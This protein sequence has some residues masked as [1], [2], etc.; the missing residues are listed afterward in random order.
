MYE[1]PEL[2]ELGGREIS[3]TE[4]GILVSPPIYHVVIDVG[5]AMTKVEE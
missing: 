2:E 1:T 4:G 3:E 5:I